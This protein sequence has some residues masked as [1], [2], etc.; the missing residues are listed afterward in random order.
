MNQDGD[1]QPAYRNPLHDDHLHHLGRLTAAWSQIDFL[2]SDTIAVILRIDSK[3]LELLLGNATT[4]KRIN[5]LQ[6]LIPEIRNQIIRSR[7]QAFCKNM[8]PLLEKR[9]HLTH[10]IWGWE[11]DRKT[12]IGT[13]V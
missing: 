4:G 9:N 11:V 13:P 6:K 12:R 1:L 10:G 8:G 5:L 3:N 2:V 7:A